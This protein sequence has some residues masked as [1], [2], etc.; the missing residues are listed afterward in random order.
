ML[1]RRLA[2]TD[3]SKKV[4]CFWQIFGALCCPVSHVSDTGHFRVLDGRPRFLWAIPV[5]RLIVECARSCG[6]HDLEETRDLEHYECFCLLCRA[7]YWQCESR[8]LWR[9]WYVVMRV[10][11]VP[12]R[13]CAP[14]PPP[15]CRNH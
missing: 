2:P 13:A 12:L 14:K 15:G 5:V 11:Q 3:V 8:T 1:V 7:Q 9:G 10:G 4:H 6:E